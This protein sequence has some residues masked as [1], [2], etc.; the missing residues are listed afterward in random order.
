MGGMTTCPFSWAY[1]R[2]CWLNVLVTLGAFMI[3]QRKI[4]LRLAVRLIP[5]LGGLL[6]ILYHLAPQIVSNF[7]EWRLGNLLEFWSDPNFASSGRWETWTKLFSFFADHPWLLIFGIGYKTL[8]YTNLIGTSLIADNGFLSIAFE[9]GVLGL[10]VFVSLNAVIFRSLYE[11]GQ[12][13]NST[14]RLYG[15]FLFSFWCGEMVQMLTGDIFT[16]WRNL[17]VYFVLMGLIQ[18]LSKQNNLPQSVQ[19]EVAFPGNGQVS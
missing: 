2:G 10:I 13:Q 11:T 1:S 7:F 16:Y 17:V 6:L 3:L 15:T 18:R 19:G 14:I 4:R 12:H 9:T 8:P 5:L